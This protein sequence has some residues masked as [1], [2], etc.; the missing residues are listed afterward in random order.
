[1]KDHQGFIKK[2][3]DFF[4]FSNKKDS[5][6]LI[7]ANKAR[8]GYIRR[9][10]IVFGAILVYLAYDLNSPDYSVLEVFR[11]LMNS[12]NGGTSPGILEIPGHDPIY[13]KAA[14]KG[15][16]LFGAYILL[17]AQ[18]SLSDPLANNLFLQS[19]AKTPQKH[20]RNFMRR[21]AF[22]ATVNDERRFATLIPS[23]RLP[24]LCPSCTHAQRCKNYVDSEQYFTEHFSFNIW[25]GVYYS[26]GISSDPLIRLA[27]AVLKVR[28][29]Y[30]VRKILLNVGHISILLY[31]LHRLLEVLSGRLVE[32]PPIPL[33]IALSSY[34]GVCFFGL[35]SDPTAEARHGGVWSELKSSTDAAIEDV[36]NSQR[37]RQV[38]S[39]KVCSE[40]ENELSFT[41]TVIGSPTPSLS[42]QSAQEVDEKYNALLGK[43]LNHLDELVADKLVKVILTK[44]GIE[45]N[46]HPSGVANSALKFYEKA[47]Q[48]A[49]PFTCQKISSLNVSHLFRGAR[50]NF[51]FEAKIAS[52]L[53]NEKYFVISSRTA[54]VGVKFI[55]QIG[56]IL[57][58]PIEIP[59]RHMERIRAHLRRESICSSVLESDNRGW[60]LLTSSHEGMFTRGTV[61]L[62]LQV[63]APFVH[64]LFF[65]LV[66]DSLG[67]RKANRS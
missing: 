55:P 31:A 14:L 54:G 37:L 32:N 24:R 8:L 10:L 23:S 64:R 4:S 16:I 17:W 49:S 15:S 53:H 47:F 29:I 44:N 26:G 28:S 27:I 45:Q 2:L 58:L 36:N 30:Y 41:R 60:I 38:Y 34:A 63:L 65:E 3:G 11:T 18:I 35:L 1:M 33:L 22:A 42:S 13:L 9:L 39:E 51:D 6:A 62:H 19:V 67:R 12:G 50:R 7:E 61:P 25:R 5:I 21:Y 66:R 57:I 43:L 59:L 48:D 20:P 40:N 52:D 46:D 56:S